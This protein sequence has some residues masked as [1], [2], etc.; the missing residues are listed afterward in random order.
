MASKNPKTLSS[1]ADGFDVPQLRRSKGQL[2]VQLPRYFRDEAWAN[3]M[4]AVQ[5]AIIDERSGLDTPA[6]KLIFDFN[7]C[8]WIDP[9]P[10]I[11]V[12]LE[13]ANA[14]SL[15][16]QVVVRVPEPDDGPHPT[17]VG[18]YQASPNRLLWFLDQEGFF[19]CLDRIDDGA[20]LDY[21]KGSQ[22][23]VYRRLRVTPSYEDARCIAM[24]LFAVP[25][26]EAAPAFAQQSVERLL[27]GVDSRLDAKVAPQT[28]ERLIYKLRVALQEALHNA[29]EHAYESGAPSRLL[30]IYVRYRTGGLGL[31]TGGRNVFKQH[32]KEESVHCPGLDQDWLAARKGCLEVFLL[33]RGIGMVRRFELS[34]INLAETY[35]FNQVMKQTFL[36]GRSSKPERQTLYGG[37]HLLHNLLS[38]TGDFIRGLEDGTWF[39]AAAPMIRSSKQTHFLTAN[40]ARLQGLAMHFRLGW[41]AETDYGDKWAKFAHGE[42]SEVWPELSFS[43]EACASS[44]LWF[45]AQ[46]VIDERFADLTIDTGQGDWILWL[47]KPHRMKWDILSYLERTVAS[48]ARQKT[49]L[50]I[51]DIPSYEAE[52][53]AAAL[54][55]IRV[56]LDQR[57]PQL[58]SRV[59]LCTNR[60]RFAAV[61]YQVN[62]R[63]HGFSKLYEDFGQL[64]LSPPAIEPKPTNFRLAIVR[65]I[66]WHDSR[67]FWKEVSQRSSMFIPENVIW[68]TDE[69]GRSKTIS[70]YIDFPQTTRN[71][72]CAA[73]YRA[74]LARVLG[75][76]PSNSVHMYP[77]DRLTMTVLREIHST[78]I[79][80]P[81]KS[82][83]ATHLALGSVLV[84]GSTLD[85]SDVRCLDLHFF[86]HLSSPLRGTKPALLFW[87]P[88]RDIKIG[89][90]RLTRIGKTATI[91]PDGW[92]SFEVPRFDEKKNCVGARDPAKTYRDW[93]NANP[94]IVKA[95]HWSY[96]GHHDFITVNIA[97]AVEAAFLEKNDLARFLV[98]HILPFLGLKRN[99]VDKNWHRLLDGQLTEKAN[100]QPGAT[101][102]G[103]LVY[104]SH[105]SSESVV[106]RLLE[107][108]TQ[109]GRDL[110]V[111][112]IFPILPVRMRWSGSTLLIPPLVREEIRAAINASV[113]SRP[114]LVFDDAAITGRTLHD[115]RAALTT[116][117]AAEILTMVI[118]NRLRQP[119]DP[120]GFEKLDY[121]WRLDVPVMGREGNCPLCHARDLAEGFSSALASNDAKKEISDWIA[122]W[123]ENSPSDNWSSGLRPLPL[124]NPELNKRYCCRQ[125]RES[126]GSDHEYLARVDVVRST[127]LAIHVSEL[128]AMTGRDDYS[129]KKI[130]EHEEP[131]VRIELAASQLLLF[132]NEFDVDVRI[133]LVQV[134]IRELA[135]LRQGSPH[136][137]L[138]ALVAMGGLGLLDNEAKQRAAT[139]VSEENWTTRNNYSA[140]VLLSY[141]AWLKLTKSETDAFKI[142]ARL[143]STA[144]LSVPSKLRV[145][146]LETLSP[147]GN[148]HSEALPVLIDELNLPNS[149]KRES[150][151]DA[152]DSLDRLEDLIG[153]LD[154]ALVRKNARGD[155]LVA[156]EFRE[157]LAR[158]ARL[159]L[160]R[161]KNARTSVH[162]RSIRFVLN[163]YLEAIRTIADAYFYRVRSATEYY[164][165]R[166][167]EFG[168]LSR[169]IDRIDWKRASNNKTAA[170]GVPLNDR[171]RVIYVSASGNID[172][173]SN[174]GEVWIPWY[175]GI[176]GVLLDLMRN[177]A[178]AT[179]QITDPWNSLN[180]DKADMWIRVDYGKKSV[181]ITLANACNIVADDCRRALKTHRW[182]PITDIGG[183]VD[184]IDIAANVLGVRVRIPYAAY[185]NS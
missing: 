169:I 161:K 129:L 37:L 142:G 166:E 135:K 154:M 100:E 82:L 141:L 12:L 103:L 145:L 128:H 147:L 39:A 181:D 165:I 123:G 40:R 138:A 35:K 139:A 90:S 68:S 91:A 10:L 74:A 81:A 7:Q 73:I 172:F 117:G 143:L 185:L 173:D 38:D 50:V 119:A 67:L 2:E 70:G 31:D 175:Q 21:P 92:K 24:T 168:V 126:T 109:E 159:Q 48:Y 86:V 41:K 170:S 156:L 182:I 17:E 98:A 23:D 22:R 84:S 9:V 124:G 26:E 32:A 144:T 162:R 63:R 94:V 8:R 108:L 80:E 177:A 65:W 140:R 64:K 62:G 133:A 60:W 85:A 58:F 51:A 134:L 150:I 87:L 33:D 18:P 42:E 59:I 19:D 167:L 14:R 99:H 57:W 69:S 61:D 79:Y 104:R 75:V 149:I 52:T 155:Y 116:I 118:V 113:P 102:Y 178:Y 122:L 114:V 11:S 72:L 43:P 30:A 130:R 184:P 77:L 54:A 110:A 107:I 101:G 158:V 25:A 111:Q 153:G 89:V 16:I 105:P 49:T 152:I 176:P 127:G 44:F 76:L 157:R 36:E 93:Q 112:R 15:G 180:T 29:Q 55:E 45:D 131:E 115:L 179:Q 34:N 1:T 171:D 136:A 137:Q 56:N 120:A 148:P 96:Q 6:K 46:T 88:E 164:K 125:S 106:R 13:I 5:D 27:V 160:E 47:V 20:N 3:G 78:E 66:K 83:P 53:Y 71:A 151:Q 146:F 132:G 121:Y 183:D 28:R 163:C 97:G 4:G 95:G 174:A